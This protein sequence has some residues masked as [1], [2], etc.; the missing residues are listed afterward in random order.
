MDIEK[1]SKEAPAVEVAPPKD[2][3]QVHTLLLCTILIKHRNQ[4]HSHSTR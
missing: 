3:N 4:R 1:D 2:E